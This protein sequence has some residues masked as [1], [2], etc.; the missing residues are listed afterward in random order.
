[1]KAIG[2]AG[3]AIAAAAAG[4][5]AGARA[6][7]ADVTA[8]DVRRIVREELARPPTAAV[9]PPAPAGPRP[10]EIVSARIADGVW[11]DDDRAAVRAVLGAASRADAAAAA[12]LLF[13]ALDDGRV[14]IA[15]SDGAAL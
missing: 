10:V 11:T 9:T 6:R 5:L 4:W 8:A 14:R 12:S 15:T 3:V 2:V 7:G 13:P 1:M